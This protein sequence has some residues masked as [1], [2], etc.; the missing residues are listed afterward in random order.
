MQTFY[1]SYYDSINEPKAKSFMQ[2]CTDVIHRNKP[3]QLYFLFSSTGGSVDAGIVMFNYLR[4]LPVEI[5]M[6]NIGSVDSMANVVFLA[7]N[8]RYAAPHSSF[9]FHGIIWPFP[10][11]TQLT[12]NQLQEIRSRFQIDEAKMTGIIKE[13]TKMSLEDLEKLFGQ[14]ESKDATF[15]MQKGIIQEIKEAKVPDGAPFLSLNFA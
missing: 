11:G 9:L 2:T 6:H 15:A 4:A 12:Y 3:K 1:L 5:I 7:A 14:G 10:Q 8:V 13:R